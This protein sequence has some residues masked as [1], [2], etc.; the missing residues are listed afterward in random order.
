M[1]NIITFTITDADI[2]CNVDTAAT[3]L[4]EE[5]QVSFPDGNARTEFIDDCVPCIIDKYELYEHDPFTYTP[6]YEMEVLD[7]AEVYGYLA[8]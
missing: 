8:E 7:L 3:E 5:N 4:E 1:R 2:R 6:D